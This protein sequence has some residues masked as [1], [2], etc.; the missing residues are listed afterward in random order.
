VSESE[1]R[2]SDPDEEGKQRGILGVDSTEIVPGLFVGAAPRPGMI[3]PDDFDVLWLTTEEYQPPGDAF[4][5][6][7]VHRVKLNDDPDK[8]LDLD[9]L[10]KAMHAG[11]KVAREV[12][13]GKRV[14]VTCARGL[15]RSA[16]VAA[17]AL[18]TLGQGRMTAKDAVG[19]LRARRGD[20]VLSESS[21]WEKMLARYL[22]R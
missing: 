7:D 15:N 8:R 19:L 17:I 22:A 10:E 4:P 2:V 13:D 12:A 3:K 18:M 16:F 9:A 6:V 21:I 11:R 20:D 1:T 5:G 14:L